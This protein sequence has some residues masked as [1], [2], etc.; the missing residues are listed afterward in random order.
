MFPFRWQVIVKIFDS[1][2]SCPVNRTSH[3]GAG[4][5]HS[6]AVSRELCVRSHWKRGQVRWIVQHLKQLLGSCWLEEWALGCTGSEQGAGGAPLNSAQ[7]HRGSRPPCPP[8][9]LPNHQQHW[10]SKGISLHKFE[11]KLALGT[12]NACSSRKCL[13]ESSCFSNQGPQGIGHQSGHQ[14]YSWS[15]S[16]KLGQ[17]WPVTYLLESQQ[18][19]SK[20][21]F[22]VPQFP[23]LQVV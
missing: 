17:R 5:W 14:R 4:S 13:Q 11:K 23:H 8:P 18:Q 6:T 7:F 1:L 19:G 21:S 22:H 16:Y 12:G 9:H 10:L 2:L 15:R 3:V 20:E